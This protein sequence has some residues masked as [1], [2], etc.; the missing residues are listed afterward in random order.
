MAL[1]VKHCR[2]I[3]VSNRH[4]HEALPQPP[5]FCRRFEPAARNSDQFIECRMAF[6]QIASPAFDH[7]TDESPRK[8]RPQ[9]TKHRHAVNHVAD[10]TEPDNQN[11]GWA[12]HDPGDCSENRPR[13]RRRF[14]KQAVGELCFAAWPLLAKRQRSRKHSATPAW[15]LSRITVQVTSARRLPPAW[16]ASGG[17]RNRPRGTSCRKSSARI[18]ARRR[19]FSTACGPSCC[20]EHTSR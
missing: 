17:A 4:A 2:S 12:V 14:F 5:G 15:E 11:A 6:E 1:L 7:P 10:G 19:D 20:H 18:V 8:C 16:P 9:R 13:R 3:V